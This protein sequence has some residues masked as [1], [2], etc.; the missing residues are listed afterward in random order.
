LVISYSWS[1][2]HLLENYK[3]R[4]LTLKGCES[5]LEAYYQAD[6]IMLAKF[7]SFISET[8]ISKR[9]GMNFLFQYFHITLLDFTQIKKPMYFM[10]LHLALLQSAKDKFNTAVNVEVDQNA[11]ALVILSLV[12]RCRKMAKICNVIGGDDK[13][14]PYD[15][16][17]E[18]CGE[19]LTSQAK[20]I[21][22]PKNSDVC[23]FIRKSRSLHKYAI[24][25]FCYNQTVLGRIEDFSD[26]W[27]KEYGFSPNQRQKN[28]LNKFAAKYE[29]FVEFVFPNTKRKLEIFKEVVNLVCNEAP[30]LRMRTFRWRSYKLGFLC[31]YYKEKKVLGC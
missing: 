13:I 12:L 21:A 24:M 1:T 6:P 17:R 28:V 7:R 15:Y 2:K 11:G 18:K 30:H 25:C 27:N 4:K 31:Y 10:N 19:F 8:T 29:E 22:T 23:D 20:D 3:E 16:I 5:L 9:K 14:S 26:E